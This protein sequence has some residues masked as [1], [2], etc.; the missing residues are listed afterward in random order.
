MK[1]NLLFIDNDQKNLD[2]L[3]LMLSKYSDLW[4]MEFV[5]SVDNAM[6]SMDSKSYNIVVVNKEL[7]GK[8]GF[9]MIDCVK[10]KS[11]DTSIIIISDKPDCH[12]AVD[13]IKH[14]AVNFR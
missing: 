12:Y 13:C 14:G 4:Q 10:Q 2:M 5:D 1:K 9:E 11:T 3:R 8:P 7:Q 6:A